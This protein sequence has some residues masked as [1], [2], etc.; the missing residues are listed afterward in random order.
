MALTPTK[1]NKLNGKKNKD[2][3]IPDGQSLSAVVSPQGKI[4]FQY[5]F[6][7]LTK[8]AK[9]KLGTYPAMS[10]DAARARVLEY[11]GLLEQGLDPRQHQ[12]LQIKKNQ[13]SLSVKEALEFW[14]EK[15]AK[16]RS[17]YNKLEPLFE[18]YVY[19]FVGS[20]PLVK[21]TMEHWDLVFE[22]P[23]LQQ[24][25]VQ[26]G[27]LLGLLQRAFRYVSRKHKGTCLVLESLCV[28]DVGKAPEKCERYLHDHELGKV[29]DFVNGN[30]DNNKYPISRRNLIVIKLIMAFG[31]R[32][33][34][35]RT[36]NKSDFDLVNGIW[37]IKDSKAGI[38]IIRPIHDDVI[39]DLQE[40]IAM[41][42]KTKILLPPMTKPESK[43][44]VSGQSLVGIPSRVSSRLGLAK[45]NMHDLR[46]TIKTHMLKLKIDEGVTEKVLGHTLKGTDANYNKHNYLDEQLAAYDKWLG[47][48]NGLTGK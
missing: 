10:I 11:K 24:Y 33:K 3:T 37:T 7:W 22:N 36:A 40:L 35:L 44:P 8:Q 43:T 26:A 48:L 18:R 31:D 15:K 28:E 34:E 27:S 38:S 46:R 14:L 23:K 21:T 47:H 5:R 4:I 13:S 32:T 2:C 20:M 6:R 29:W 12:Q 16:T 17:D 9:M 45:W 19:S 25:P 1:L 42:P 41:Y 39:S 30:G